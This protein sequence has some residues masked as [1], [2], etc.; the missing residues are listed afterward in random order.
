MAI[1]MNKK[2]AGPHKEAAEASVGIA[3]VTETDTQT[4]QVE[5]TSHDGEASAPPSPEASESVTVGFAYKFPAGAPYHMLEVRVERRITH[6]KGE[7]DDAFE[8][9]K[10]WAEMRMNELVAENSGDEG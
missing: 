1:K 9:A 3:S 5:A 7:E 10:D 4:G 8:E 2:G 6:A